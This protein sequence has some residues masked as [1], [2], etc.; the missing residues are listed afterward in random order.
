MNR[1]EYRENLRNIVFMLQINGALHKY[2][3]PLNFVEKAVTILTCEL[4]KFKSEG[5][6]YKHQQTDFMVGFSIIYI[7]QK[8][9][10]CDPKI[11]YEILSID[12]QIGWTDETRLLIT[13]ARHNATPIIL[14]L[15]VSYFGTANICN[16]DRLGHKNAFVG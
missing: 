13:V 15:T 12:R 3:V 16:H 6:I 5:L 9:Y 2:N 1:D 4:G 11:F 14:H 10:Y 8:N 7:I